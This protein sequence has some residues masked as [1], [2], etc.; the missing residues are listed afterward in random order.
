ML[1]KSRWTLTAARIEIGAAERA[2]GGERAYALA[3]AGADMRPIRC[4]INK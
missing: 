1:A 4:H 2:T 3:A